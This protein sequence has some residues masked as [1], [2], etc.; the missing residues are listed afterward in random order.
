VIAKAVQ[1]IA[2]FVLM[3]QHALFAC[4]ALIFQIQPVLHNALQEQLVIKV[5][6]KTAIQLV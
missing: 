6:V 4:K 1:L 2:M 3:P 5:L